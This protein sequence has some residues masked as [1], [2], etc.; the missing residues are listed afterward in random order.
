MQVVRHYVQNKLDIMLIYTVDHIFAV[1]KGAYILID[2]YIYL[3][4]KSI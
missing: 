4:G 3:T 2:L 1:Q